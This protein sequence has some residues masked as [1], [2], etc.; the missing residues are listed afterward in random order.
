MIAPCYPESVANKVFCS[1]G[2]VRFIKWAQDLV[3]F[4]KGNNPSNLYMDKRYNTFKDFLA[5]VCFLHCHQHGM[6]PQAVGQVGGLKKSAMKS[7][8][9]RGKRAFFKI[10]NKQVGYRM[11][12]SCEVF[13]YLVLRGKMRLNPQFANLSSSRMSAIGPGITSIEEVLEFPVKRMS[14]GAKIHSSSTHKGL[15][16]SWS[17]HIKRLIVCLLIWYGSIYSTGRMFVCLFRSRYRYTQFTVV[18]II[19]W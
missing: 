3:S 9:L 11:N 1:V 7:W 6:A 13:A 19:S 17:S 5:S 16:W 10:K 14:K 8:T 18:I 15:T 2:G 4:V 12:P